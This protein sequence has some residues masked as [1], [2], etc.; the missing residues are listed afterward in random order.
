MKGRRYHHMS[1]HARTMVTAE[2]VTTVC[3]PGKVLV[4]GGYLVLESPNAGIVLGSDGERG[5]SRFFSSFTCLPNA[6]NDANNVDGISTANAKDGD[7]ISTYTRQRLD[8]HSPQFDTV[9]CYWLDYVTTSNAAADSCI[10]IRLSPRNLEKHRPNPFVEKALALTLSYMQCTLGIDR[11]SDTMSL[12]TGGGAKILCVKLRAGND[13]YSPLAHLKDRKLESTPGNVASLPQ[14]L[15]CPKIKDEATGKEQVVVNKTG[16]GSSAALVTSVVGAVLSYFDVVTLPSSSQ[17]RETESITRG[18]SIVHNLAQICHCSAQGKVGSGFDVSAAVYGSHIYR[19]FSKTI[20]SRLL[21]NIES[22]N[23]DQ[24]K[25]CFAVS[26]SVAK[27][28]TQISEDNDNSIW[29]AK[30]TPLNLPPG[31][32]LLMADVCGGSESPSMARKVLAWKKELKGDNNPW[33]KLNIINLKLEKLFRGE[34]CEPTFLEFLRLNAMVLSN[35]PA[36]KWMTSSEVNDGEKNHVSTL[37]KARD[38]FLQSREQ[39]KAMGE[40]AG[41][42]IE[43]AGQ[44]ALADA[45]MALPGVIAAGVPGAGGYDALFVLYTKGTEVD[46]GRSDETRERI[47]ELWRGWASMHPGGDVEVVCPLAVRCAGGK[48]NGIWSCDLG[49]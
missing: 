8:V 38:L 27:E 24:D 36:N 44:T 12:A 1:H 35:I 16:M 17:P 9:F 41:V 39:L 46:G 18:T 26:A 33:E 45:T 31:L 7:D 32:E 49:W 34:F 37:L 2:K 29:D 15:P 25:D 21:D 43:P 4:A 47:G 3:C 19:R 10:L 42:P 48:G 5:S 28:L 22:S 20:L 14:F 13:F 11:F 6:S 30:M 40:A 23:S